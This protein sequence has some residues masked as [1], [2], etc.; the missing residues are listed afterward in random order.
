[1]G[2][3][4]LAPLETQVSAILDAAHVVHRRLG[5]GWEKS[6]Y[7]QVLEIVLVDRGQATARCS[8]PIVRSGA[9]RATRREGLLCDRKI[10][11]YI[12]GGFL[13]AQEIRPAL[14]LAR[15]THAVLLRITSTGVEFRVVYRD[16]TVNASPQPTQLPDANLA[17]VE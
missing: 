1:M 17:V 2:A 4:L 7:L 9:T 11:V 5:S 8:L 15:M 13:S 3:S 14:L 12:E 16:G 6:V 10:W